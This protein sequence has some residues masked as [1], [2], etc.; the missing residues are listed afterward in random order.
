[1]F[2]VHYFNKNGVTEHVLFSLDLST[3]FPVET[4][5]SPDFLHNTSISLDIVPALLSQTESLWAGALFASNDSIYIYGGG[6]SSGGS[7]NTLAS[8]N[9]TTS[10]WNP[11]AV[12]GGEFENDS[13]SFGQSVSIPASG[14]AFFVGGTDGVQGMLRF[15]ESDSSRI[16]WT[17]QTL[18]N[19]SRGISIPDSVAG[20]MVYLP[21]GKAGILLLLG[22]SNVSGLKVIPSVLL[23]HERLR[24]GP[25][26][27][28]YP[29]QMLLSMISIPVPGQSF[30]ID[31]AS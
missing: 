7:E 4:L 21:V 18:S 31:M 17:N 13:R 29:W 5:L 26:G 23:I 30:G 25:P 22:G 14:L 6:D 11:V 1:M 2:G 27:R 15:D 8:Y 10:T 9:V 24:H 3:T 20:G 28:C 16:S 12:S 19:G